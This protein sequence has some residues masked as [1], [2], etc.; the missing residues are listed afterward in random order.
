MCAA[1]R[2]CDKSTQTRR[3]LRFLWLGRWHPHKGTDI[4][5]KFIDK[6]AKQNPD[7]TFTIAG[8]GRDAVQQLPKTL[9]DS[10]RLSVVPGFPRSQLAEMLGRHDVGLFTSRTEGWGLVLM[11]ML[12][13]GLTVYATGV[14]AVPDL[15]P[16]FPN[17][18]RS[19]PPEANLILSAQRWEQ[20][21]EYCQVFNWDTIAAHYLELVANVARD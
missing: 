14:G 11:E 16:F 1:V 19:F 6:R 15:K 20:E 17:T 10:G 2:R 21:H 9:I 12:E 8:C 13:A 4:L 3:G 18:L 7:D 5:T